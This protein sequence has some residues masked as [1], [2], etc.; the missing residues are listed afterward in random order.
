MAFRSCRAALVRWAAR[1]GR[2]L[3]PH[4]RSDIAG[5]CGCFLHLCR[6]GAPRVHRGVPRLASRASAS[7]SRCRPVGSAVG[8]KFRTGWWGL[9]G[10]NRPVSL[11]SIMSP[12]S[13]TCLPSLSVCSVEAMRSSP[14][15]RSWIPML[16]SRPHL[17]RMAHAWDAAVMVSVARSLAEH[18]PL[19]RARGH[20]H[21]PLG[22]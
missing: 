11:G 22:E 14:A 2:R 3:S 12:S 16:R 20:L 18:E 19:R 6:S 4:R 7:G 5:L 8:G 1:A 15:L 13:I 9:L 21:P 17:L 10:G